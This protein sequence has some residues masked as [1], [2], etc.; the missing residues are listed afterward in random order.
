MIYG[1]A[2]KKERTALLVEQAVR[3]GFRA[4]DTANQPK[5]YHEPGVGEALRRLAELGFDRSQLF[6]QTKFTP[7]DGQDS[8]VPYDPK[9]DVATQFRQSLERS[10]EN[11]GTDYLDSL[12]LHSPYG[13]PNLGD[14]DWTVWRA[15]ESAQRG[16]EIRQIGISN[17]LPGQL[18]TLLQKALVRPAFVQNRCFARRGWDEEVR[19]LCQE[20]GV[21]YQGF[22]LLTANPEVVESRPVLSI[23]HTLGKTPAQ[24]VF[25]FSRQIGIT[26][27]TGTTDLQHMQQDLAV[28]PLRLSP[29]QVEE[30]L[31][32]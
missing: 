13:F 16:G 25:A 15:M 17:V 23:A 7:L 27:L 9:A 14:D 32:I 20:F 12:L 3:T 11:L 2:W 18:E 5:H 4:I 8:R 30:I 29:E 22:S 26:P 21:V 31:S 24:I 10:L 6:L 19:S 28:E 1:T